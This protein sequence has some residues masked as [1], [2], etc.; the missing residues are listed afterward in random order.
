MP[1]TDQE[2]LTDDVLLRQSG[3]GDADAFGTLVERHQ[4]SVFRFINTLGL[5]GPDAEDAL[6]ETFLAAWR[7]AGGYTAA[8]S[9]RSWLLTIARHS[10]HHLRRRHAGQPSRMEPLEPLESLALRAGWGARDTAAIAESRADARE[11]V[12]RALE[13]LGAEEREVLLLRDIEGFSGEE[14][15]RMLHLPLPAMKSRL[16]RARIHLAAL[17][18]E[19]PDASA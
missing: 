14:A 10:T 5:R 7:G 4:A 1:T 3:A 12:E 17:V 18:R 19:D 13:R 2:R 16:H 6:Q 8:G 15:A 9:A 11:I